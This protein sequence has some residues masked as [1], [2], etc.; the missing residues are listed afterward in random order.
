[1][2]TL[3]AS[4]VRAA[5]RGAEASGRLVATLSLA[6]AGL[7]IGWLIGLSVTPVVS[8]VITSITAS[9]A[10]VIAAMSGVQRTDGDSGGGRRL[11]PFDLRVSP[12]PLALL[13]VGMMIGA[14]AGVMVR[15]QN[16]LGLDVRS[17]VKMWTDLKVPADDV[18]QRLFDARYPPGAAAQGTGPAIAP[19]GLFSGPAQSKCKFY[20]T[21]SDADLLAAWKTATPANGL[22]T[23]LA[24]TID[25]PALFRKVWEALCAAGSS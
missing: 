2:A 5:R 12:V 14:P 19:A 9:A 17:E 22:M 4:G 13:M 10:A 11:F 3:D 8:I 7:G 15:S 20:K 24:K 25:E 23:V 21:E 18:A 16:L 6:V 1:M